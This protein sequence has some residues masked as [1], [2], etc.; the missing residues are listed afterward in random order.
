[1][2]MI[3]WSQVGCEPVNAVSSL[4]YYII[5]NIHTFDYYK[6]IVFLIYNTAANMCLPIAQ[7]LCIIIYQGYI[8]K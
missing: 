3:N 7:F 8:Q 5:T 1:M 2:K 6:Y 4:L